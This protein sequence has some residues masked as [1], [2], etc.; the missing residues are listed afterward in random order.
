MFSAF[1]LASQFCQLLSNYGVQ[2]VLLLIIIP[3]TVLET[4]LSDFYT[5]L[6]L[7]LSIQLT[8][9]DAPNMLRLIIHGLT[10]QRR[11][12]SFIFFSQMC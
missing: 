1:N 5:S 9:C 4:S 2:M 12:F 7:H 8:M 6:Y 11:F 3:K 10:N